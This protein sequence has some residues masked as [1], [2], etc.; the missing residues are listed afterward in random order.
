M[1]R[2]TDGFSNELKPRDSTNYS[3]E[4]LSNKSNWRSKAK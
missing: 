4:S 2:V 1:D 3:S